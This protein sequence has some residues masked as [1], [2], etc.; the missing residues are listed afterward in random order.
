MKIIF[1]LLAFLTSLLNLSAQK[2][3]DK[4]LSSLKSAYNLTVHDHP[5]HIIHFNKDTILVSGYLAGGYLTQN[6][7]YQTFDGGKTWKKNYFKGDAWIYDYHFLTDGK[8]W[9]GGSDEYVHYSEDF[10][11]TWTIKPRP[12]VPAN[13][14]HAIYMSDSLN[15]IAGGLHNGLALTNDNWR[16]TRQIPTPLDQHK[17]RISQGSARNRVDKVQIIDSLILINQ[18]DHIY[19]S[20]CNLIEWKSFNVPVS[21][22]SVDQSKNSIELTHGYKVYV[23]DTKLN[24]TNIYYEPEIDMPTREIV[25]PDLNNFLAS[26]IRSIKIQGVKYDVKEVSG[27]HHQFAVYNE[28]VKELQVKKPESFATIKDILT[29]CD[30]YTKPV[31]ATFLF[32]NEDL[33][34]YLKYYNKTKSTRQEVTVWGGD[35]SYLLNLDNELFLGPEKT[36]QTPLQQLLDRVYKDF[37]FPYSYIENS[38]HFN[39][40]VV[41]NNSD[42][43]KITNQT[44]ALY[45]LPWVIEHKNGVFETYD[46][47]ITEFLK[48][49][50]PKKFNSYDTLLAGELIYRLIEQRITNELTYKKD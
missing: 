24:L 3:N 4:V 10:G 19:Y 48:A 16:T 40:Y 43:L 25:K 45:S 17:F 1:L 20:K 50:L 9:M 18:N 11:S 22:F 31:A 28:K 47:R 37:A 39:I 29:T 12:L 14:V 15:G 34:D 23:L 8:V 36:L 38:P 7:V 26:V 13:R 33:D 27:G 35:F 46:L 6:V 21:N 49:I 42:T 30:N 41:N 32:S 5:D 44:S 2:G